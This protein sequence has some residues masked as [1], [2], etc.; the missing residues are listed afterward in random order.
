MANDRVEVAARLRTVDDPDGSLAARLV[1]VKV[2]VDRVEVY[3][4]GVTAEP[5]GQGGTLLT[6]DGEGGA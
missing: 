3:V 4:R 6:R 5:W 2:T 1:A